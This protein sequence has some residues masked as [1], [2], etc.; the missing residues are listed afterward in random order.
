MSWMDILGWGGSALLVAS[1]LQSSVLRFRLLNLIACVA[2]IVFNVVLAVWPMVGMNVVLAAINIYF[3]L[4]LLR[5]RDD[6]A[7]YTVLQVRPDDTYLR[8]VLGVHRK[9]IVKF[10]PGFEPGAA[11]ESG[12]HCY[13]VQRGDETVGAVLIRSEGTEAQIVL[14]Y[15]TPR[16]RDFTPGRFVWRQ[17]GLLENL[18]VTRVVSRPGMVGAYYPSLGFVAEGDRYVLTR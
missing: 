2:L 10:N 11:T 17:S 13:L 15:V 14:D 3:I 18:G 4:K 12:T 8:H 6:E 9:D 7:C 1:L 5:E 16:F